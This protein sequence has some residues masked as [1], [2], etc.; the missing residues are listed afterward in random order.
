MN[1]D[2]LE[3]HKPINSATD[4]NIITV[5]RVG[6]DKRGSYITDPNYFD[7]SQTGYKKEE[8][9]EYTIDLSKSKTFYPIEELDLVP[10]T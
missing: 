7:Y 8:A 1:K 4:H 2:L 6:K 9:K 10:V 3:T 5:Y